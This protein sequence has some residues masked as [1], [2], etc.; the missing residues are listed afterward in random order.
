MTTQPIS[1][2]LVASV[3][4][5]LLAL[6][7]LWLPGLNT[8]FASHSDNFKIAFMSVASALIATVM[9][10]IACVPALSFGFPLACPAGGVWDW[11]FLVFLCATLNRGA[12]KAFQFAT[13][14]SVERAKAK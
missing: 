10:V 11:L 7:F 12:F 1:P 6:A 4:S 13:P 5:A 8:W 14:E 3:L 2:E 9:I